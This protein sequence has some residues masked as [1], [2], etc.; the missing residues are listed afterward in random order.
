M[1]YFGP[2]FAFRFHF[3]LGTVLTVSKADEKVGVVIELGA[4]ALVTE[5]RIREFIPRVAQ[6]LGRKQRSASDDYHRLA[7]D[8]FAHR[9]TGSRELRHLRRPIW[10]RGWTRRV[11]D[12]LRCRFLFRFV[13]FGLRFGL[14][15]LRI[16]VF[17]HPVHV[18]FAGRLIRVL[19]RLLDL[20]I[21]VVVLRQ[22]KS[23]G[24]QRKRNDGKRAPYH[25]A[26]LRQRQRKANP[27]SIAR[28]LPL[29]VRACEPL[30][31]D[32]LQAHRRP[33]FLIAIAAAI[34]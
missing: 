31:S 33:A 3:Y 8:Y 30:T 2:S 4:G 7:V 5:L 32:F 6:R 26:E 34:S 13:G 1:R 11:D 27:Y 29:P 12:R 24:D 18:R 10:K 23:C 14:L 22:T 19:H 21:D 20:R 16:R 15:D 17:L 25:G 9:R 28:Q